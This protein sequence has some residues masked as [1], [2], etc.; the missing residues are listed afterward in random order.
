[1]PLESKHDTTVFLNE[2]AAI[3]HTLRC[4]SGHRSVLGMPRRHQPK[5]ASEHGSRRRYR[6]VLNSGCQIP[7][8]LKLTSSNSGLKHSTDHYVL[9]NQPYR[10]ER[11]SIEQ[12]HWLQDPHFK[13][14]LVLPN[15]N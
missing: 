14:R 13:I 12:N 11:T 9:I 4:L 6:K 8:M 7:G 5:I 3:F 15:N 10:S 1:M 2:I